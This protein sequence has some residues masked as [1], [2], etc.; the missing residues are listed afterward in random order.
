M[1]KVYFSLIVISFSLI[2]SLLGSELLCD[3]V[4]NNLLIGDEITLCLHLLPRKLRTSIKLTIDT[5]EIT[6]I[7]SFY[8]LANKDQFIESNILFQ[9]GGI[10][11]LYSNEFLN[12]KDNLVTPVFN[13]VI[14]ISNGII[15]GLSWDNNCW[16]CSTQTHTTCKTWSNIPGYTNSTNLYTENVRN[17]LK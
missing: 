6:T 7:S 11:S 9:L 1:N 17:I 14:K 10:S 5:A 8:L 16:S 13:L 3:N 2:H 12:K 4:S 15:S